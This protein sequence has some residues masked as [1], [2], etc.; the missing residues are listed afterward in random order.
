MDWG[1]GRYERIAAELLPVAASAIQAAGLRPGERVLDV[2][3][4]TGNAALLAAE[5]GARV[6][7]VD[8]T[9]SLLELAGTAAEERGL[10]V[11]LLAGDAGALPFA[12]AD[13]DVVLSVFGVI[14]APDAPAAAGEL[15]RVTTPDGRIVLSAWLPGGVFAQAMRLRRDAIAAAGA[16]GG[17]PPGAWH[18]RDWVDALLGPFGFSVEVAEQTLAF[19]GDSS[20][21]FAEAELADHPLW[22][23]TRELLEPR[24]EWQA[25]HDRAVGLFAA[26]NEDSS[27]FRVTSRYALVSARRS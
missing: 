10:A 11:T 15:A 14:F 9:R 26:A 1:L 25:L 12:D 22:V 7:G 21:D 2:G 18:D 24:G 3:C 4:G 27:G 6:V 5:R 13:F 16:P 8:P 20:V 19:T 17:P 23:A